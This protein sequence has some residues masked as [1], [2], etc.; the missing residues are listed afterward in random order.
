[1]TRRKKNT[2]RRSIESV[3]RVA[4]SFVRRAAWFGTRCWTI[5]LRRLWRQGPTIIVDA[6]R[7]QSRTLRAA[8]CRAARTYASGVGVE[9][10]RDL[11]V[12]IQRVVHEGRQLNALLQ[13]FDGRGESR[14][15][16]IYLALSVNGR[17]VGEDELLSA[18]RHQL[19][20]VVGD[21]VGEPALSVPLDLEVPR[22]RASAP[23]VELRPE[24]RA[25]E[26]GH[27]RGAIPIERIEH[28]AS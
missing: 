8:V 25:S 3:R 19:A 1:M 15:Y 26:N 27:E 24:T 17:Q 16:V 14:R 4:A 2:W 21:V 9:L 5:V 23:V 11:L 22:L 28:K 10:T 12:I 6:R 18:F 13:A 20:Q 7:Q